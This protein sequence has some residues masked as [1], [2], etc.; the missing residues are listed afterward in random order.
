[1][2]THMN[3]N[4]RIRVRV[5]RVRHVHVDANN[6][7][8]ERHGVAVLDKDLRRFVLRLVVH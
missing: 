5:D 4:E 6:E 2:T 7:L 3:I 1:M 8:L